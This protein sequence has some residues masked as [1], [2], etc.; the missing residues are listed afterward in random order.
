M[1]KIFS[2]LFSTLFLLIP[3]C[4]IAQPN[5]PVEMADTMR[6]SGKIYVVVAVIVTLFTGLVLYII[7]LDRKITKL[8]K[9]SHKNHS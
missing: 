1:H 5:G 4:M 6:S 8:E 9:E 3:A 7:S 2:F